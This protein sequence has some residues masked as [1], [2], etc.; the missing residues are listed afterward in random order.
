MIALLLTAYG[1]A[2]PTITYTATLSVSAGAIDRAAGSSVAK[3]LNLADLAGS[4]SIDAGSVKMSVP[5]QCKPRHGPATSRRPARPPLSE[6]TW[7]GSDA[8]IGP[9]ILVQLPVVEAL[10][11]WLGVQAI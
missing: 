8:R 11:R 2:T 7:R 10:R 1:Y 6:C 3:K 4:S 9:T 5:Y